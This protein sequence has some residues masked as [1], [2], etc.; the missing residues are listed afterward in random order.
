MDLTSFKDYLSINVS[1]KTTENYL[2][3]MESFFR[4]QP[5][6]TQ[7]AVNQYLAS[8][9]D[10]WVDG[11]FNAFFKAVKWYIKFTKITIELPKNKKV[12]KKPRPYLTEE[13]INDILTK[14]PM[15][16]DD[17]QKVRIVI[18][19]IF[20]SGV[21]PNELYTLRR[22]NINIEEA[23]IVLVKTKTHN[24]RIVFI[25]K[26][27][28][29]TILNYF[30][31]EPE[32]ENAFNLNDQSLTYYCRT[33]AKHLNIKIYP[34]MLRHSFAHNYYKKSGNDIVALGKMLGHSNLASTQIY[35]DIDEKEFRERYDKVFKNKKNKRKKK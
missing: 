22:E 17:G 15:I 28:A 14:A 32:K 25:P 13:I 34:Y 33:I 4:Y 20:M 18:E 24:A 12:E 2:H 30:N 10:A 9:V 26:E 23:K 35:S 21:R 6:F 16:F 3:Q 7:E 8:K 5:E 11:S 29:I 1:K 19:L 27:L 31:T